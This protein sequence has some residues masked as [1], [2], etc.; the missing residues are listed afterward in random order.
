VNLQVRNS[1]ILG[2]SSLLTTAE[3]AAKLGVASTTLRGWRSERTGPP[4]IQIS[5]RCIRYAEAD[6]L[7]FAADRRVVPSVKA[8]GRFKY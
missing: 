2:S 3:A 8:V 6:L 7:K 4:Y 1:S 5:T